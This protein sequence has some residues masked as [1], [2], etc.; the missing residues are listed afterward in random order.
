MIVCTTC[1]HYNKEGG[2]DFCR[3]CGAF[4]DW[5]GERVEVPAPAVPEPDPVVAPKRG[6]LTRIKSAIVGPPSR[7][8]R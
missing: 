8:A 1:G 2:G 5:T 7:R 4:L 6:I 3:S